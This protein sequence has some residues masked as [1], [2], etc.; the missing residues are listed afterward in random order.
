M[1]FDRG[2]FSF[3]RFFVSG[4]SPQR[5][6]EALLG[7]L[8][9]KAIG[10]DSIQ[11]ADHSEIGWST[12]EHILD[13]EF[14]F[15]KNAVADG[16]YF[17]LRI[18]TNKPPT[19]LVRSYQKINEQAMLRATGREFLSKAQRREAR[20]QALARLDSEAKSGAFRRM[21]QIP[22]FWDLTRNELYFGST[23]N[24][25]AESLMLLF[26]ETF[27]RG[28]VAASAGEIAARWA[29]ASGENRLFED[30]RPAHFVTPPEGAGETPDAHSDE[31][32]TND[33]LGTEWLT[34]LWYATQVESSTITTAKSGA[35]TVL[36]EKSM[37]MQC[38]FRMSGSVAVSS[39]SP[40]RLPEA[41]VALSGGKQP[42]R[43]AMQIEAQGS[44]FSFALR[45]DAM[46]FSGVQ[47]PA[48]EDANSVRAV[49]EDRMS[50]LRDLI[51]AG[52]GLYAA[53][54][55]RRLSS[56]WPQTLSA[57]RAWIA[58]C[59]HAASSQDMQTTAMLVAVS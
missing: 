51:D 31:G 27:D 36:F 35:V 1:A 47:L 37:Q 53:F 15:A 40:T 58:S 22:V 16:L 7:Q 4:R 18:D 20:E 29:A 32:R 54:L 21:K 43:A 49:F 23:S 41:L 39:D 26:R 33:F 28:V 48:P 6:D 30:C 44:I 19:E 12:G 45:G 14:D 25:A 46:A 56:K 59:R 13:T 8:A 11:T 52:D 5:V 57:M 55:K 17:A 10:A 50:R 42:V 9:A 34:W 3:K 2:S 38:A 24:S